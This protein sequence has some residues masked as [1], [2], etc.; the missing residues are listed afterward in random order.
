M[1]AG[2]SASVANEALT[3]C[4]MPGAYALHSP[5]PATS[6]PAADVTLS[7][8]RCWRCPAAPAATAPAAR[9]Q[10]A[11]VVRRA[12]QGDA[13]AVDRGRALAEEL[14]ERPTAS[15]AER[16]ASACAGGPQVKDA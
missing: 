7:P 15:P 9:L 14:G 6:P 16:I 2:T 5:R 12:D 1:I 13:R 4:R 8:A 10:A 3:R 11:S